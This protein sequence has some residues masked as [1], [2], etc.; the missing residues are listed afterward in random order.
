MEYHES[1]YPKNVKQYKEVYGYGG[2]RIYKVSESEGREITEEFPKSFRFKPPFAVPVE[3]DEQ[4]F[5]MN[6]NHG[7]QHL[8][9]SLP[10]Q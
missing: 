1:N 10:N 6:I 3:K 9:F 7:E 5:Y 2:I 8:V 4:L